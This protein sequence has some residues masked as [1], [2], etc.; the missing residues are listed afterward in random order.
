MPVDPEKGSTAPQ[1]LPQGQPAD[2]PAAEA[3]PPE[4]WLDWQEN[5]RRGWGRRMA[6]DAFLIIAYLVLTALAVMAVVWWWK[7]R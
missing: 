1:P 2:G 6:V 7:R 5:L 3:Q 4:D